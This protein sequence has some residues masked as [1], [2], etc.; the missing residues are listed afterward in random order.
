MMG[1]RVPSASSQM[2]QNW[3]VV[4]QMSVLPFTGTWTGWRIKQRAISWFSKGKCEVLQLGRNNPMYQ[5][6]L[7]ANLLETSSAGQDLGVLEDSKLT[8]SQ[9]RTL[10]RQVAN[11]ILGCVGK[12]I[13]GRLRGGGPFS[14]FSS[15]DTTSG[16]K[17]DMDLLERVL[18]RATKTIKGLGHL[19]IRGIV[20]TDRTRG[21]G[22]K[23]TY[24]KFYLTQEH[25][26]F[27]FFFFFFY[28][29]GSQTLEQVAQR[30]CGVFLPGDTPNQTTSN[31]LPLPQRRLMISGL[32]YAKYCQEMEG[33]DPSLLLSTGEAT[34]GV[35]APVL[36]SP[37]QEGQGRTGESP[38]RGRQDAEGLEHLCYEER[39]GELGLLSLGQ[40]RLRG[41]NPRL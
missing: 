9:Q 1:Q 36:G 17:K 28:C 12:S 6:M 13:A 22:H 11:S 38:A 39:L 32:L 21:N 30:G 7:R 4:Y 23:L 26:F 37:V 35:L 40:S 15:G 16:Y 14:L 20:P 18:H 5:Y 27:F 24:I 3:E 19:S 25:F 8:V 10:T 2:I 31:N 34:P 41:L 33:S 29:E